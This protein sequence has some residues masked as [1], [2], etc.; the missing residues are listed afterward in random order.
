MKSDD[1]QVGGRTGGLSPVF[2]GAILGRFDTGSGDLLGAFLVDRVRQVAA[3]T[4]SKVLG[5]PVHI[6]RAPS[7]SAGLT[8]IDDNPLA[9]ARG[10]DDSPTA[11]ALKL[12]YIH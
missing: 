9:C 3:T 7:A 11:P 8:G 4:L 12:A 1:E 10:S 5:R 6:I 2:L